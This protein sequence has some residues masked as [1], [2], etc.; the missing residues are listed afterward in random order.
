M[1]QIFMLY[2]RQYKILSSHEDD[3]S[4]KSCDSTLMIVSPLAY[5][6]IGNILHSAQELGLHITNGVMSKL[7][8]EQANSFFELSSIEHI[9]SDASV[10]FEL[11]G[12]N[13]VSACRECFEAEISAGVI[14]T[15]GSVPQAY[16]CLKELLCNPKIS[17]PTALFTHCAVCI[18]KPH[19]LNPDA[20]MILDLL[21]KDGLEISA[22]KVTTLTPDV[23]EKLMRKYRGLVP[24][25][26][27]SVHQL[28]D[29]PC[30][31]L[32]VRE[33][34]AVQRLKELAGP[35]DPVL[36]QQVAPQSIRALFGH[37][38]ALNAVH[39]TDLPEDGPLESRLLF[40]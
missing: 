15:C 9:T 40:E 20:G 12:P 38:R 21:L 22:L 4:P 8:T 10:V 36:A 37:S 25:F 23:V 14:H 24:D 16:P 18:I 13:A 32:E 39:C 30:M 11:A 34:D 19:A 29:G 28:C 3:S 27:E 33:E 31:L 7:T 1:G 5:T 35:P 26:A 2:G 6:R 17:S